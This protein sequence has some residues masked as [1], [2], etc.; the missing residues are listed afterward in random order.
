MSATT[1]PA[2][3][4]D[5]P[6]SA[7]AVD[8]VALGAIMLLAVVLRLTRIGQ[9]DFWIDEAWSYWFIQHS[10]RDLLTVVPTYESN[11]PLY[12][13]LLKA[14]SALGHSEATLRS[15]SAVFSALVVP[16]VYVAARNLSRAE[17]A[18]WTAPAAALLAAILPI[19]VEYG[20]EARGYAMLSLGCAIMLLGAS[21]LMRAQAA[22]PRDRSG[23]GAAA[24]PP[25][26][27][28][29]GPGVIRTALRGWA[30]LGGGA[31]LV[32][33]SHY[34][35]AIYVAATGLGCLVLLPI[36]LRLWRDAPWRAA[37]VLLAVIALALPNLYFFSLQFGRV[38]DEFWIPPLDLQT[39]LKTLSALYG[40]PAFY[41]IHPVPALILLAI[42][43]AGILRCALRGPRGAGVLL[44]AALIGPVALLALVSE[45]YRPVW[46]TRVLLGT[47]VPFT[48]AVAHGLA[49][50][51]PWP[52]RG[53]AMA[54]MGLCLA[55]GLYNQLVFLR[56]EPWREVAGIVAADARPGDL[57]VMLGTPMAIPFMHYFRP[58]EGV[59][60]L[61]I[62]N[63]YPVRGGS[64]ARVE[65]EDVEVLDAAMPRGSRVWLVSRVTYLH[66][67]DRLIET[68]IE[69]RFTLS[70]R[71]A[72]GGFDIRIRLFEPRAGGGAASP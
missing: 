63:N 71:W 19:Q 22:M 24:A 3:R 67:P 2:P 23:Q 46:V 58:G 20:Q 45:L 64:A 31:L 43:A 70:D 27:A 21:D 57:V 50:L 53:A 37:V 12:Y 68:A 26:G 13:V 38:R 44:A 32:I 35:A 52:L 1:T 49:W 60:L 14:W 54:G 10:Y 7:S 33:W 5:H 30:C 6:G 25:D 62:P 41:R 47:T 15:L 56:K 17:D 18:R 59:E 8:T 11:P 40:P 51:R 48:I 16:V 39:F 28:V 61:P 65:R 29:I 36:L 72:F 4:A 42:A 55:M 34:I 69:R 66:D 9:Y